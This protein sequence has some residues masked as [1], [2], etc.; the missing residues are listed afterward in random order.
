MNGMGKGS[1]EG[2]SGFSRP[3]SFLPPGRKTMLF[4]LFRRRRTPKKGTLWSM[5]GEVRELGKPWDHLEGSIRG[6]TS[7]LERE[8]RFGQSVINLDGKFRLGGN[9]KGGSSAMWIPADRASFDAYHAWRRKDGIPKVKNRHAFKKLSRFLSS[10]EIVLRNGSWT[11]E[12][13][14][15]R[16]FSEKRGLIYSLVHDVLSSLPS[17]HLMREAF[18]ELQ[19]GG[20]G[21]DGA[22]ASAYEDGKIMMYDFALHGAKR[23]FLGL[24]L[25]ELG[26]VQE[27][28]FSED[29]RAAL[30]AKYRSIARASAVM[31]V[32]FLVDA[33][34]RRLYQLRVFEEFIA[35]TYMIYTSQGEVLR[36][37]IGEL[38]DGVRE[39]W[40]EVYAIFRESFEGVEYR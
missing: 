26:H 2:F 30:K 22:K 23:T 11:G 37:F 8:F 1:K 5:P 34:A 35:E 25:H 3:V 4:S 21:P 27:A 40:R 19:L 32:E 24:L 36:R 15:S 33:R 18:T 7:D 31:G 29:L 28:S 10:H 20:W 6:L 14:V 12:D 9:I 39:D 13:Q 16:N 38:D 17:S